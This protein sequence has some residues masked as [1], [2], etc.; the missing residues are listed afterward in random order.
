[1]TDVHCHLSA[2][3]PRIRELIVGRD[4]LGVHPWDAAKGVPEDLRARLR[5]SPNLGVGEIGLDRLRAREI[6]EEMR[7]VFRVQLRLAGELHRVVALHG[8]KC[9]GQ[10]VA[11]CGR[12]GAGVTAWL[13]HGFSRAVGL[14]PEIVR[15]NGYVS[16]GPAI[17]NDHAVNY[18]ELARKIP[19]ERLLVETDRTI[20][21]APTCPAIGEI[22]AALARIRGVPT[23]ALDALLDRNADAFWYNTR[24]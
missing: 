12:F 21:S 16:I 3:D 23:D 6:S 9:W 24:I 19:A 4:F 2:N 20:E 17:L 18:R 14:L 8:A 1:M 13:F 5:Q 10:V 22:V 15:L 11:E 7:E